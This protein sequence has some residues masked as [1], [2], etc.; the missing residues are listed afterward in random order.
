LQVISKT[1]Q[2]ASYQQLF[3]PRHQCSMFGRRA[4]SVAG[5]LA[6]NLLLDTPCDSACLVDSFQCNLKIFLF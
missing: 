3:V 1:V 4:F 6:S 5:S 2:S